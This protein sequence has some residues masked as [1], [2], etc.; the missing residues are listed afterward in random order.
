MPFP[1]ICAALSFTK[2][3]V[4]LDNVETI[5]KTVVVCMC[6]GKDFVG[7]GGTV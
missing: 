5:P 3:L 6:M 7:Y 4:P 2:N 1:S